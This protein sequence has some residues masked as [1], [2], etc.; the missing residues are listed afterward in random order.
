MTE[1]VLDASVVLKWFRTEGER[2]REE[3]L[4]LR[5]SFEA[6]E[7]TVFAP[8]LLWLEIVNVAARRW[9]WSARQL[10]GL[11]AQLPALS[12]VMLEPVLAGVSRWAAAGLSAYDATYVA[13]AEEAGVPL[14]TDDAGILTVAA[15]LVSPLADDA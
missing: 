13:A 4:A 5:R 1:A 8:P 3:A 7:L 12:F 2:H 14:I 15:D 10:D 11:A 9:G 6:G